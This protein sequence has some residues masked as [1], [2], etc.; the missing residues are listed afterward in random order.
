MSKNSYFSIDYYF[1]KKSDKQTT[2]DEYDIVDKIKVRGYSS[3]GS[4]LGDNIDVFIPRK[5]LMKE[6]E[7]HDL[8]FFTKEKRFYEAIEYQEAGEFF[9]ISVKPCKCK[10]K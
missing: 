8:V 6:P 7:E 10:E 2:C 4:N 3:D 9:I 5:E 1:T